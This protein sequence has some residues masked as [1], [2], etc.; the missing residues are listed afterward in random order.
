MSRLVNDPGQVGP[1]S[2][3][4]DT[5]YQKSPNS[6]MNW[7]LSRD[8]R[9]DNSHQHRLYENVGPGSYD[10]I[11][12]PNKKPLTMSLNREGIMKKQKQFINGNIKDEWVEKNSY[13]DECES[14]PGPGHYMRHGSTS[15]FMSQPKILGKSV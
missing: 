9:P 1:G 6:V 11:I 13:L 14:L 3:N 7:V 2:Y 10:P 12:N 5:A 15:S 8:E 4:I